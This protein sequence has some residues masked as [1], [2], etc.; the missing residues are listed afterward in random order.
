MKRFKELKSLV[1]HTLRTGKK[2]RRKN[3]PKRMALR[4]QVEGWVSRTIQL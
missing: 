4:T 3:S 1:A 2:A